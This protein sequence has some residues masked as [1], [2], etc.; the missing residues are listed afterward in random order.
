M[1]LSYGVSE[2]CQVHS[3][4]C[5]SVMTPNEEWLMLMLMLIRRIQVMMLEYGV[6]AGSSSQTQEHN[7]L[8]LEL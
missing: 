7:D 2:V 8:T 6:E 5:L 3:A 4:L 1:R